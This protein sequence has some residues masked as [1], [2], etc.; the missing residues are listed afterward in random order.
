MADFEEKKTSLAPRIRAVLAAAV[1]D[2]MADRIIVGSCNILDLEE[3]ELYGANFD[4]FVGRM[5]IVVPSILG[6]RP[7]EA[8]VKRLWELKREAGS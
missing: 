2:E 3:S 5:E 4:Q 1:G 6:T 7:G 8:V